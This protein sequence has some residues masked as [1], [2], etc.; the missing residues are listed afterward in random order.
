MVNQ[1]KK[2]ED[3]IESICYMMRW[4]IG[5]CEIAPNDWYEKDAQKGK[6]LIW[7]RCPEKEKIELKKMPKWE[8]NVMRLMK[9]VYPILIFLFRQLND[10]SILF[11]IVEIDIVISGNEW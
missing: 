3:E 1:E 5:Q 9:M 11:E 2:E 4:E 6:R 8:K 7:K 10:L